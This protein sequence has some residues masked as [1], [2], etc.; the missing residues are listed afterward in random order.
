MSELKYDFIPN[1]MHALDVL[2]HIVQ[3][4]YTKISFFLRCHVLI[5]LLPEG[6]GK[7]GAGRRSR[8][9]TGRRS[10]K[11]GAFSHYSGMVT[12]GGF[13]YVF[14]RGQTWIYGARC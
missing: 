1:N 7:E 9:H 11:R 2:L 8:G 6:G 14:T 13:T 4:K 10:T 5:C 12:A 3:R